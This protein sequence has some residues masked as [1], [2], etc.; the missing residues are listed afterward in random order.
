MA[1]LVFLF[2][3]IQQANFTVSTFTITF[4]AQLWYFGGHA[5]AESEGQVKNRALA[6]A[7]WAACR[8]H[9]GSLLKAAL[10]VGLTRPIRLVMGLIVGFTAMKANIVGAVVNMACCCCINCF[11]RW[12]EH[13]NQDAIIEIA[14]NGRPFCRAAEAHQAVIDKEVDTKRILHG[15]SRVFQWA[16][17]VLM[18]GLGATS[19]C[20]LRLCEDDFSSLDHRQLA[21][22]KLTFL[23]LGCLIAVTVCFPFMMLFDTIA[24]TILY[25]RTVDK[26]R[27]LRQKQQ[28]DWTP[29][30][31]SSFCCVRPD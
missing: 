15:A 30:V 5:E 6:Q 12:L 7:Y 26:L 1:L 22:T 16:G 23:I 17:L 13:L 10:A 2:F 24:D 8:Y 21:F 20:M 27:Y 14:L 3:W 9:F 31:L 4:I 11:E 25:I 19:T 18:G 28:W 29:D